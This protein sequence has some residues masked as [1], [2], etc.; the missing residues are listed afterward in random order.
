MRKT[1]QFKLY[2]S[3]RNKY[4]H[5][6]IDI[7]AVIYNHCIALRKRY[8]HLFEKSLNLYQL[9]KHITKL[10]RM[11]R[12]SSWNKLG[13]QAVQDIAERIERGYRL[14]F[15]SLKTERKVAPPTFKKRAKYK[16][17]T[18]KQA[19]YKLLD[20]NKIRIGKRI[21]KFHKSRDLEG[22]VKTLTV[23][24]DPLGD[25]YLYF[26]CEVEDVV[27]PRLMTGKSAGFDFGLKTFLQP[28]DGTEPIESPLFFRQGIKAVKKANQSLSKKRL[29]SNHRKMARLHLAR[30][31]KQIANQRRDF[32]FQLA[33]QLAKTYDHIFFESLNIKGMQKMWGRKVSDL[34]FSDF[35]HIQEY[36]CQ[37][38]GSIIGFIDRFFP[39]SKL[40]HICGCINTELELKD[41][42]WICSGCQTKHN[43]DEN[44]AINILREGASSLGLEDIR[45]AYAGGPCLT[46]EFHVL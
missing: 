33:N 10:K 29:G 42:I 22:E 16:S 43:R 4:L 6:Q 39:S 38:Q 25:I 41:R 17:F 14:F 2:R 37:K 23:K 12:Y 46:P 18:L 35:V 15:D 1:F 5:S 26:S 44:A 3:K 34:G 40:C 32:H 21:F 24:R 36:V 13:S 27:V 45:P 31:H 11:N 28:S 8:Y 20:D 7:A 19:G 9:Q 30:V